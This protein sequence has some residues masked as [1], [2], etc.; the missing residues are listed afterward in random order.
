MARK[1]KKGL[2]IWAQI[3]LPLFT[4][5]LGVVIG[6]LLD[7]PTKTFQKRIQQAN[8]DMQ[9]AQLIMEI[10]DKSDSQYYPF[11][12]S[13][14]MKID[15]TDTK[16]ALTR[17]V[18]TRKELPTQVREKIETSSQNKKNEK[19]QIIQ[20]DT[21]KKGIQ[22]PFDSTCAIVYLKGDL[23]AKKS[24][25]SIQYCLLNC[26]RVS[27]YRH[28][29][30]KYYPIKDLDTIWFDDYPLLAKNA[31]TIKKEIQVFY[32]FPEDSFFSWFPYFYLKESRFGAK[33]KEDRNGLIVND[34][35]GGYKCLGDSILS[36]IQV[37][38]RDPCAESLGNC[39]IIIP[40]SSY[41]EAVRE[42]LFWERN[43]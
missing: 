27:R 37:P 15:D 13:L 14:I 42:S 4:A 43:R 18:E 20:A 38:L 24:A 19:S 6:W 23:I 16:V 30:F 11:L 8:N 41:T 40:P 25:D 34:G 3:I 17:F 10:I 28:H 9:R 1:G 5:I 7:I 21:V 39:A 31:S 35:L 33:Y 29:P 2:P 36:D 12:D 22:K 32:W 26:K